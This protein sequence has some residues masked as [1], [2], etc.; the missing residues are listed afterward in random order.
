MNVFG[1]CRISKADDESI[2]VQNFSWTWRI[3]ICVKIN[4]LNC[5]N[6]EL[7]NKLQHNDEIYI[8]VNVGKPEKIISLVQG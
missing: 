6:F 3:V 8:N 1:S 7:A 2:Q 5:W 4:L